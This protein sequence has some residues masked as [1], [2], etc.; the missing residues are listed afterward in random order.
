MRHDA[1]TLGEVDQIGF[2]A[3]ESAGRSLGLHGDALGLV[4]HVHDL[5][6][7]SGEALKDVTEVIGRN[8][9]VDGLNRLE[10]LAALTPLVDDLGT[11]DE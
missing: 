11:G 1:G 10:K 3:D 8:I 5:G 9:D 2:E 4:I 6:L 7:A